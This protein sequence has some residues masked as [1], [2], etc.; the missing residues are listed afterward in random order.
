HAAGPNMTTRPRRAMTCA[1]MPDGST[2]NGKQNVLPEDY[3]N[4]LTVGD[5]L[6]DPKQNELIWHNSWTD[7]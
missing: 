4:S 1:F 7:R 2:F 3:F 5:L 6:D